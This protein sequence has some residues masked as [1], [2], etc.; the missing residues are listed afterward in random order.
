MRPTD[1]LAAHRRSTE[2]MQLLFEKFGMGRPGAPER[3]STDQMESLVQN[4]LPIL[5]RASTYFVTTDMVALLEAS[6]PSLPESPLL[7]EEVPSLDGFIL[8]D[9][10][11]EG[12]WINQ[13]ESVRDIP[14][15]GYLWAI[16][17]G[18]LVAFI[19]SDGRHPDLRDG[20]VP[21][22]PIL[23][24]GTYIAYD[25]VWENFDEPAQRTTKPL[26]AA[27][28]FMRQKLAATTTEAVDR[29]ERRRCARLDLPQEV[30]VVR[31][32]KHL[33]TTDDNPGTCDVEWSH[34]WLVAGH[35]RQQPC[36]PGLRGRR[37]TWISG[38]VKGPEDKPLVIKDRVTAWV[39]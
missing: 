22:D 10:P 37:P 26:R 27:W 17:R 18:G 33:R 5:R 12:A 31:V 39:R 29:A 24:A 1:A 23:P 21:D 20:P 13:D 35:W 11:L 25:A 28:A 7:D 36:G 34:R 3:Y 19:L 16:N 8:F 4:T 2:A 6:W 32:R 9:R 38:Y 15:C 14:V 30:N